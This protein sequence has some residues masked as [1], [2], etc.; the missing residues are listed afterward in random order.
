MKIASKR[1]VKNN[2]R[3]LEVIIAR[4]QA[5]DEA[6]G[7]ETRTTE[8]LIEQ[9]EGDHDWLCHP[10]GDIWIDGGIHARCVMVGDILRARKVPFDNGRFQAKP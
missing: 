2:A 4:Y 1:Q 6:K 10:C 5:S 8:A 9:Y 3:D 7:L